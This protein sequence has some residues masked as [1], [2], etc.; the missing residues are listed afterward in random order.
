MTV[1][2]RTEQGSGHVEKLHDAEYR[3]QISPLGAGSYANAQIAD[4]AGRRDLALRA[5]VEMEL[6]ARFDG[7]PAGTA[8]F[9]FWNAPHGAKVT[10]LRLPNAAWFFFSST[11]SNL[12]LA[13]DRK[14]NGWKAA[15]FAPRLRVFVPLLPTAPVG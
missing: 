2:H 8:G 11:W 4:Y 3:L 9:G 1:L 14:A 10:D 5:P 13:I 6:F 15:V 7:L 12:P